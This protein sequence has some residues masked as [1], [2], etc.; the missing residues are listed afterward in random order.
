MGVTALATPTAA[1]SA[2]TATG[3]SAS[4]ASSAGTRALGI[5]HLDSDA[6]TIQLA[7]IELGDR[8]LRFFGRR[9]LDETEATRLT[10]KPVCDHRRGQH[11]ARL[12]E[13]F[14]QAFAGGGVRETA[15][16]QL[17]RHRLLLDLSPGS[18]V[19]RHTPRERKRAASAEARSGRLADRPSVHGRSLGASKRD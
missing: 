11:V 18:T 7:T 15:D 2:T 14:P 8:V 6:A 12:R 1:R 17:G 16:I 3:P 5:R 4:R 19:L 9:H 13:E 10:R